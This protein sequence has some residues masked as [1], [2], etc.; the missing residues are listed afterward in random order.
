MPPATVI[1]AP[2][3]RTMTLGT[4]SWAYSRSAAVSSPTCLQPEQP[5]NR[6]PDN[7]RKVSPVRLVVQIPCLNEEE[8]LPAVLETIPTQ[9]EGVDEIIVL[10]IDDGSTDRTVEVAKQHGV[11]H[12]VRHARNRG[13]GRSFHDGVQRALEL[14]ADIV[15]NTDG[16]NQYP[17]EKIGELV[18]PIAEGRAEITIA[19]RQVHL[20]EHFSRFKVIMQKFGSGVVNRAAGTKLPDAAS[21]FRAYSRDSLMLLNTIT[22]FSYCMETIIQA[23]NKKLKIE[24]IPVRT[25]PKTRESRLFS[26]TR[27]HVMKSA[28]AIIRAY[29]MYKPYAIFSLFGGIFGALGLFLFSRFLILQLQ[30]NPGQ[31]VQSV[32]IGAVSWVLAFLM[33]VIGITADL[34][35]TNRMLIEDTL[36]HTKKMR[37]GRDEYVPLNEEQALQLNLPV[38]TMHRRPPAPPSGGGGQPSVGVANGSAVV[39]NPTVPVADRSVNGAVPLSTAG[40]T[41]DHRPVDADVAASRAAS[42]GR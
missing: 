31:H 38:G 12:F 35:R 37:F 33:V 3:P 41:A 10:V 21:G 18:R 29:I 23:G 25:N 30:N 4:V 11:T 9:I 6:Q 28:G 15:V 27:E 14:G 32:I 13:L 42:T 8:T 1:G 22:R 5:E 34:I 17:Q 16:D 24:S 20:V 7:P 2:A 26:S 36:E 40:P 39:P 19:D